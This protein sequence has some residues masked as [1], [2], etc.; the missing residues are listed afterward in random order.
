MSPR[1][2]AGFFVPFSPVLLPE[3]V[4]DHECC[5]LQRG[6]DF[7]YLG[8]RIFESGGFPVCGYGQRGFAPE[9]AQVM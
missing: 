4:P 5:G 1:F 3:H 8:N 7:R 2:D 9:T 6:I